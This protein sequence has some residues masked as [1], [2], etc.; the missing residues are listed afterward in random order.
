MITRV[1]APLPRSCRIFECSKSNVDKGKSLCTSVFDQKLG[2]QMYE[3]DEHLNVYVHALH[4]ATGEP[5]YRRAVSQFM[6]A[7]NKHA[8][9]TRMEMA[10]HMARQTQASQLAL[11]H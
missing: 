11:A 3:A 6:L 4:H 1:C 5:L 2:M 7:R 10:A 8:F 9:R